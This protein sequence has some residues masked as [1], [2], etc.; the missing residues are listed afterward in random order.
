MTAR[1]K[2]TPSQSA[3]VERI[4]DNIA[5]RSGAGCG[6]TLVLARR[7]THLLLDDPQRANPL[8]RLV[9][10]TFTDKAAMEMS[11]RVR[12]LLAEAAAGA[13]SP[14]D[15]RRLQS[16]LQDLP[17]ARISTIHSFCASLL[18]EHAIEAGLDP[19][20]AVCAEQIVSDRMLA[21]AVDRAILAAADSQQLDAIA[22]LTR[23]SY[24]KLLKAVHYL[25][26]NR[27]LWQA[28]DYTDPQAIFRRWQSLQQ[29]GRENAKRRLEQIKKD[30]QAVMSEFPCDKAD[31]KLAVWRVEKLAAL[32][33][34]LARWSEVS[35]ASF[36]PFKKS[37]GGIGSEKS[38][39]GRAKEVRKQLK[40]LTAEIY[41][42]SAFFEPMGDADRRAAEA[43]CAMTALA[44]DADK[45]YSAEKRR[46]GVLDFAD[47]LYHTARLIR[48][49][50]QLRKSLA[51]QID[52]LLIDECQ[53]T[54]AF[55]LR[56]LTEIIFSDKQLA[57]PPPGR[58][59]V[60]GDARQSIY[61]FR[62]AWVEEF[63]SLCRRLGPSG[64]IELD[65]SFRTHPAGAA[66]INHLFAELM[67]GDFSPIRAHRQTCPAIPSVEILLADD[68]AGEAVH[69]ATS[70][71]RAQA[72]LTAQRIRRMLDDGEKLVWNA[73]GDNWRPVQPRDIAILM[74]RRTWGHE[75]QRQL[76]LQGVPYYVVAGTGFFKQQE[77][78][79]LLNALRVIDNPMDDVALFGVLRSSLIGLDDN[80]LMRIALA[81]N[82]P[83][84][85]A[86]CD[87]C[88]AGKELP[89]PPA[90]AE[91]LRFAVELL[92]RLHRRKDAVGI[93]RLIEDLL[94]ASGYE[95]AMLS[96]FQGR[97]R[98]G[99]I[100]RLIELARSAQAGGMSLAEFLAETNEMI[101]EESRYEQA[102]VAGEAED[103]VR[104]MTIHKAKGLEFP[105]VFIP[106][107]NVKCQGVRDA[108][109]NRPDWGLTYRLTADAEDE[110]GSS[111]DVPLS[112][113]LA[114][115]LETADL[116]AEDIRK[117]YVAATRHKDHLVFVGANWRDKQ[118]NFSRGDNMLRKL[119]KALGI[120]DA[121]KAGRE[122]IPYGDGKYALAVRSESASPPADTGRRTKIA[123]KLR[124]GGDAEEMAEAILKSA[125]G[126]KPA[127]LPGPL[128]AS[129]GRASLAVTALADFAYCPML[130]HWRHELKVPAARPQTDRA[131][132]HETLDAA[133][134]GTI[135][136]RCMERLDLN[137]PQ[138]AVELVAA[139]VAEM[140][141]EDTTDVRAIAAQLEAML[142]KFRDHPLAAALRE[143]Q[144]V[145]RELDFVMQADP[146]VLRGQIDVLYQDTG[147]AWHVVDY[148]SDRLGPQDVPAHAGRYELQMLCYSL[149]AGRF[150]SAGEPA[151]PDATLYFLRPGL[152]HRFEFAPT[153]AGP[154]ESRLAHLAEQL[155]SARRSG[156]F[157]R[158]SKPCP[159]CPYRELCAATGDR[160]NMTS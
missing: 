24:D 32:D 19:N 105:V 93:D 83:Y 46:R 2:L 4:G 53:D 106:D 66:F 68:I 3:A 131:D 20:F 90:G 101:I 141:L 26:D 39:H 100:R 142:T 52:Q 69:N 140:N 60:V 57:A 5:L 99:N 64:R 97:R 84:F 150:L 129:I 151:C 18:R 30:W 160:K 6:K 34:I 45:L 107:L 117:L 108:L 118:G 87:S 61:R 115:E 136:H 138:P 103:V 148:K 158:R 144:Q 50:P 22:L 145:H 21:E 154:A 113:R 146:A 88:E 149:A 47:L 76:D 56:L 153:D 77:V 81:Y 86:L 85:R 127:V 133:T 134:L 111:K 17:D 63:E 49:N 91:S 25:A 123:Q 23:L 82:T 67:A 112:Y 7:F 36:E 15:R 126:G 10:L 95:A 116:K 114:K 75:Y 12:R 132:G 119:D 27:L 159:R 124:G 94:G 35:A 89:L 29:A 65:T 72:A 109:M 98:V 38:W 33:D 11:Q 37:P 102:A 156:V 110:G 121:L 147:G 58:L 41:E 62:G 157:G 71:S 8:A 54:D 13:K 28:E 155:I 74:A 43:I 1:A 42:L 135:F 59:F 128:P 73:K 122:T 130:Y 143:A 78:F 92:G 51:G 152:T 137:E 79:D 139:A 48:G 16:W 120:S 104:I 96:Q 9:A 31:D 70:A 80:S 125:G 14:R 55:Q 40:K 44:V